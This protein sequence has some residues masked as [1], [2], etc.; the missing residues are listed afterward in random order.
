MTRG[1]GIFV[2]KSRFFGVPRSLT[3]GQRG[4]LLRYLR[5][6][7]DG[8]SRIFNIFGLKSGR[9]GLET[10]RKWSERPLWICTMRV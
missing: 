1:N 9:N 8:K 4:M 7:F 6:D 10:A 2:K 5:G 3:V